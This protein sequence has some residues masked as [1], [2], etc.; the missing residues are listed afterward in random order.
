MSLG[1]YFTKFVSKV[2]VV[3]MTFYWQVAALQEELRLMKNKNQVNNTTPGNE[4]GSIREK[5]ETSVSSRKQH[6]P[7]IIY[8]KLKFKACSSNSFLTLS[9]V[10][11]TLHLLTGSCYM[12]F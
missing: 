5:L 4:I 6:R 7:F 11:T 9:E 1:V 10:V 3:G 12:W 8:P 2:Y